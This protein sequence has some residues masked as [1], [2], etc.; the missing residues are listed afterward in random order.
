MPKDDQF[1]MVRQREVMEYSTYL[2]AKHTARNSMLE[3]MRKIYLMNWDD[4]MRAKR[5][6]GH[7][8]KITRSPDA[9][10]Q[11]L[12]AARL[13]TATDPTFSM[14]QERNS[15][16]AMQNSDAIEKWATQC[17]WEAGR[18][19]KQPLHYDVVL[20]MLLNAEAH[21]PITRTA[22]MVEYAKGGSKAAQQR[23]ED[24]AK[25][26]P[27]LF[28][29]WDPRG[30]YP[31]LGPLGLDAYYREVL[32]T[33]GKVMD[34][35]GEDA[36]Q[37]FPD[38]K[39]YTPVTLC[40]FWDLE[41]H[42]VWL[43]ASGAKSGRQPSA[44]QRP[45]IQE[46]HGLD[47]IPIEVHFGEGS[48]L[49]DLPEE[50][51][52]PFLYTLWKSGLWE[53]QN[54]ML[55][56]LY[57]MIFG[58]GAN[59]MF[60]YQANSP[61]KKLV[62]DWSTPGGLVQ[63]EAGEQYTPLIKQVIDPSIMTGLEIA[64]Q[65]STESTIYAQTLG[66]PLGGNAPFSMVAL[67]HQAGRLPLVVPQRKASWGI[68]DAV[69][70]ALKWYKSEPPKGGY[71]NPSLKALNVKDIPDH[72][73][74]EANLEIALPQDQLQQAQVAQLLS[75]G[76]RPLVSQ[77]RAREDYL[78]IEQPDEEQESIW[79]EQMAMVMMAQFMEMMEQARQAGAQGGQPPNGQPP[80]GQPPQQGMAPNQQAMME[81]MA[82]QQGGPPPMAPAPTEPNNLQ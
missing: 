15:D 13:L 40:Q 42:M 65:K 68:G 43:L 73:E 57:T 44:Y 25:R 14:P 37:L 33:S 8:T 82:Q 3:N 34:E 1:D 75:S 26:T 39:R 77:R 23:A 18:I 60:L 38:G 58:I 61:D 71:Y 6:G 62:T 78:K 81:Q 55:T 46:K 24:I 59:P 17:W 53:R 35:F 48:M 30:C 74:I 47:F 20:S 63:I 11:L 2:R 32:T 9:R 51:R 54:L 12:G 7:N 69:R 72:F 50:Q 66:E 80:N 76:D 19:R 64:G 10:N 21:I 22:D 27:Y 28:D 36:K 4:E 79:S 67:L 70:K 45:I 31:D 29:V 56:V 16:D 52:Q 5:A 49:F 41:D